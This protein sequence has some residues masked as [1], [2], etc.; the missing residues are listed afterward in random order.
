MQF[1]TGLGRL[2]QRGNGNA[3]HAAQVLAGQGCRFPPDR[4]GRALRHDLAAVVAGPRPQVHDVIGAADGLLVVFDHQNRVAEIAQPRQR[5]QQALVVAL[6]QADA[7]FVQHVHHAHQPRADLARQ[8]YALRFA[9]GKG[10]GAA[11]QVE[12]AE[13]HVGH[14]A[15]SLRQFAHDAL[16]DFLPPALQAQRR[17][18]LE[19][20]LDAHRTQF[21][22]RALR[23]QH[24]ARR[25]VQ[26]RPAAVRAGR[27][28]QVAGQFLAHPRRFRFPVAPFHVGK[29]ALERPR[30]AEPAP[31]L[32]AEGELDPG[33]SAAVEHGLADSRGKRFEGRLRVEPVVPRQA[34]QDGVVPD[35]AAVP[36][37]HGAAR[38]AE[39]GTD[40]PFRI[41]E[42]LGAQ[43]GAGLAGAG[44]VVERK[45]P[46][47]HF[48]NGEVA[49]RA[50]EAAGEQ[51]VRPRLVIDEADQG[52]SPGQG[53][54]GLEGLGQALA[55]FLAHPQPVHDHFDR[56][57]APEIELRGIVHL[58]HG[59]V[60]AGANEAARNQVGKQLAVFSLA[61][62]HHRRHQVDGRALREPEHFIDH[63]ADGLRGQFA[64]V[65]RTARHAGAG[66]QEAH[67]VV[68]F[69]DRRHGGTRVVGGRALLD[70]DGRRKPL[71]VVH[72]GLA[73]DAQELPGVG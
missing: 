25:L 39:V 64:L 68:D 67:V 24:V 10:L 38:K 30:A 42:P 17:E 26:P 69:G 16:G 32:E 45:E 27:G 5:G 37:A 51:Y 61:V 7:R 11:V 36:A 54:R 72:V 70:G 34:F 22:D 66:E 9:P 56:V 43:A 44:R 40:D 20:R 71:D 73:H 48:R 49:H 23:H 8:P 18:E 52:D 12:I 65:D 46:G 31:G 15:Q 50:G 33:P 19:R 47:L 62:A 28:A 2:A 60:H 59:A 14:E 6:V 53:Q 63:F 57:I 3:A 1:A 21:G 13:T 41:E 35:V 58:A 55:Q 29:N 4:V